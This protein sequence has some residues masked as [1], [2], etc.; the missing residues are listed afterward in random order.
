MKDEDKRKDQLIK[1]LRER[2]A[3]MKSTENERKKAEEALRESEEKWRSLVKN[4][5]YPILIIDSEGRIQFINRTVANLSVEKVIGRKF[6]DYIDAQY[7]ELLKESIEYVMQT[8]KY[9]S[10]NIKGIGLN[11]LNSWYETQLGPVKQDGQ[12][13]AA[14]LIS[15][16]I[17]EHKKSEKELKHSM[18]DLRRAIGGIVK[19]LM[20]TVEMRDPYTSGHQQRVS[21]LARTIAT[22]MDLSKEKIEAIR[23][24]GVIHDLGK[25]SIPADILTKPGSL[26]VHE[27]GI[28]KTHS[29][30][31]YDILKQVDLPGSVDQILLQH[32]ER[33][34]GSGYPSGLKGKDILIEARI[35]GVADVV[36]AMAS[37]RPYRP[38]HAIDSALQ[39][40]S[41]NKG[42]IYD[43]EVV[44]TCLKLFTEKGFTFQSQEDFYRKRPNIFLRKNY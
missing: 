24:A 30:V 36:E 42:T 28:I 2:I 12:I 3:E 34:D 35:L 43:P 20:L 38:A 44:D 14:T 31:G 19:V 41:K 6:Y 13:A 27:F 37:H 40:I 15:I 26:T 8:G 9:R 25:I 17:T 22:Y 18:V 39:E 10:L 5:P 32:H 7:H 4:A 21:N 29:Q 33:M 23:I 1:E 11:G 16:D